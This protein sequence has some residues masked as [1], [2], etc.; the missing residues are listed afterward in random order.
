MS[1]TTPTGAGICDATTKA[2]V[3]DKFGSSV[4]CCIIMGAGSDSSAKH[5]VA[6]GVRFVNRPPISAK[7]AIAGKVLVNG[8]KG[9][10]SSSKGRLRFSMGGVGA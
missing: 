5:L 2:M 1:V 8:M 4:K 10:N 6:H 9:A 3:S 7:R